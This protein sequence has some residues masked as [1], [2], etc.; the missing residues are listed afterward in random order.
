MACE[1]DNLV[2]KERVKMAEDFNLGAKM[3]SFDE[4]YKLL[5]KEDAIIFKNDSWL[6]HCFEMD[7][8]EERGKSKS[9]AK[10]KIEKTSRDDEIEEEEASSTESKELVEGLTKK[11]SKQINN[12]TK[13]DSFQM[14]S[15]PE[16][17]TEPKSCGDNSEHKRVVKKEERETKKTMEVKVK[18]S[19][20][21]SKGKTTVKS[22]MVES[23]LLKSAPVSKAADFGLC[24]FHCPNCSQNFTC[25]NS[26]KKH[27]RHKHAKSVRMSEY[28]KY[29]SEIKVHICK[30]CSKK[31][32]CDTRFLANH[33]SVSHRQSLKKYRQIY[34]N[35]IDH[36]IR[37]QNIL[38]EGTKSEDR[39][40]NFCRYQC[41]K[42]DNM[43]SRGAAFRTHMSRHSVKESM[44]KRE[45]CI[46]IIVTHQCKICSKLLLCDKQVIIGH[47][48]YHGFASLEEYGKK[49]GCV[50]D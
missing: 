15:V 32:L 30:I 13:Q 29:V 26:F 47:V 38:E 23:E 49:T 1:N 5:E 50:V 8:N 24:V 22:R 17:M 2:K 37:L 16:L 48:R 21:V 7:E 9:L 45:K 46:K 39:I 31:V 43:Y 42:C 19:E 25:W 28:E 27:A 11:C 6:R 41:P 10:V 35:K 20:Q 18:K 3:D 12:E 4:R 33:M 14:N 40:G 44:Y 34:L 36:K